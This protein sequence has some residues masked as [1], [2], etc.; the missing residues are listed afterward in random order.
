MGPPVL[1]GEQTSGDE[2]PTATPASSVDRR[3]EGLVLVGCAFFLPDDNLVKD[4]LIN[5]GVLVKTQRLLGFGADEQL[6][7]AELFSQIG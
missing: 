7:M 5:C 6:G 2:A 1:D 4:V 3:G